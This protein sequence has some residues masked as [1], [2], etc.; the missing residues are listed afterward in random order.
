MSKL[1]E[2]IVQAPEREADDNPENEL[3]VV[4]VAS[5]P[6]AEQLREQMD[7]R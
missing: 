3:T 5:N 1:K 6:L 2:R 7:H 4:D